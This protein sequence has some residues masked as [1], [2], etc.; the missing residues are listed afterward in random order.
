MDKKHR[1]SR[2]DFLVSLNSKRAQGLSLNVIIVAAIALIV[3]VVLIMIFTGRLGIFQEQ[4]GGEAKSELS[5]MRALYGSCGPGVIPETTFKTEY[6]AAAGKEDELEKATGKAEA[7]AALQS[8][9]T[10]CRGLG[11]KDSCDGDGFCKWR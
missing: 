9:I 8:E 1:K 10:R 7:K 3:L 5:A 2:A 6:T 11:D 4:I